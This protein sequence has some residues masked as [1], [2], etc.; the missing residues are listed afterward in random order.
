MHSESVTIAIAQSTAAFFDVPRSMEKIAVLSGEAKRQGCSLI[1]FP[2]SYLPGYPRGMTFGANIGSRSKS[3]RQ[4]WQSYWEQSISIESDEVRDLGII[5]K[6]NR[7]Y[8]VIGVTERD[9]LNRSLYC[10]M[11]IFDPDGTLIG[12]HRKIKP[13]GTERVIWAEGNGDSLV[14]YNT[15]L[16]RIGGLICWENY[17]PLARMA[18]YTA[19]VDIYLAPT[20]DSRR[21]WLATM[22]HIACEGRCYVLSCNQFFQ[23]KDYPESVKDHLD[24]KQPDI[25]SAGGSLAVDPMGNIIAGPIWNREE[26]L[27]VELDIGKLIQSKFDFDPIG[28]Y[29]RNDLFSYHLKASQNNSS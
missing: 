28:H 21:S 20:A 17:M 6:E 1:L 12:K 23:L 4:L 25:I 3:G 15:P 5:A 14:T 8:L 16:G 11:F 9:L 26:L 27:T 19:G 2:E 29:T 7:L 22:Q 18:L 24:G 13:T 10:S